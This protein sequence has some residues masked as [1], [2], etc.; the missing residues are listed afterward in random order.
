MSSDKTEQATP[1]RLREARKRGDL[2][3]SPEFS[4]AAVALVAIVSLQQQ[5]AHIINGLLNQLA[6][7]LS[8]AGR[9]GDL[10]PSMALGRLGSAVAAGLLLL[11]PLAVTVLVAVI[12]AGALN[13]RGFVSL[14]PLKPSTRKL[15]PLNGVKHLF[16][17][18]SLLMLLKALVKLG[19]AVLIVHLWTPSW[20]GMLPLIPGLAASTT[21][22]MAWQDTLQMALQIGGVFV[23]IG[24]IDFGYRQFAWRKRQR[25]TKQEVK[26][27][28]M[29]SE[30]NPYVRSRMR[31]VG[32][33]RLK[34]LMNGSGIR[35]VPHADVVITNPTHFAVAIQYQAGKMR[36]PRVI[37]KGQRL[38][39]LRIKEAARQHNIPI[40]ENKPLAQA[41]FKS[42]E[43]NQEVPP[44]LYQAVAQVLAFVY[45]LREAAR[46]RRRPR[47]VLAGG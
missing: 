29:R 23:V 38:T 7:G 11:A 13:T 27:E 2:P 45:R 40:V 37:A 39:A 31:Q 28:F 19:A 3:S 43:V 32:R 14:R 30:G 22:S 25:M 18:E 5:G 16:A 36:A 6:Q 1:H 34:A 21:L 33:K 20:Q 47:A 4:G 15:N 17:K 35:R 9:G 26:E 12:V 24:A 42:V 8:D 44:D 10:A 41:L 46:P